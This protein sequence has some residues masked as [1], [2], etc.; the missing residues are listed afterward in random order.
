MEEIIIKMDLHSI[1]L[2]YGT[3]KA[4]PHNYLTIYEKYLNHFKE[5]NVNVLEIG[6]ANGSSILMWH[7][8]FENGIINGI[9]I[10]SSTLENPK[11]KNDRRIKLFIGNQTDRNFLNSSFKDES[12]DII[13]DDGGHTMEEQMISFAILFKKLKSGGIY[14]LEDLITSFW[15]SHGGNKDNINTSLSALYDLKIN[16]KFH[17]SYLMKQEMEYIENNFKDIFI[18]G[19]YGD[20]SVST[21]A[22]T[23]IIIKK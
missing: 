12:L 16:S 2:K 14:I 6:I 22:I 18:Y 15:A 3:D 1:G 17:S 4:I 13:I 5:K 20:E 21:Q 9:D 8:Y 11:L 19:A 23:S 10:N 7:E